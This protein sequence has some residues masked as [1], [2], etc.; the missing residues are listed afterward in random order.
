MVKYDGEGTVDF[1]S[2]LHRGLDDGD[3][4]LEVSYLT[5]G[6]SWEKVMPG[7]VACLGW[8]DGRH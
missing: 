5:A 6:P 3:V 2:D 4:L 7:T 8:Q 1:A